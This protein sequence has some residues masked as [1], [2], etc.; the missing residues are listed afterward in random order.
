MSDSR[1]DGKPKSPI[2]ENHLT[3]P[4]QWIPVD[5]LAAADSPR[6]A[7]EIEEHARSL[8][9]SGAA[10]PPI[11]VHR[12]TM[13]VVDG[14]HRLRA[15]ELRGDRLIEARFVEGSVEDAFVLA[16]KLNAEHGMPLSR[17]DRTAAAVRIMR[18][19][20]AWSDRRIA[21]VTGLSPGAVGSLRANAQD[22]PQLTLRIGRDGRKRP[23]DAT[24]GR[25]AASRVI[26]E[27]PDASLREIASRA[28]IAV[29]TARDVRR[30]IR[31][32]EDPVA[33]KFR[34][35]ALH[36]PALGAPAREELPADRPEAAEP[37]A[38]QPVWEG[39]LSSMR[40]DPSLRMSEIGRTLLQLLRAHLLTTEQR[41]DLIAGIP[42][43]RAADV[44]Q[45]A[46]VCASRWLEF[47]ID[48]EC[49]GTAAE[50][51]TEERNVR[52]LSSGA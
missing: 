6:L 39:V 21:A 29:A 7:G 43:H 16:V 5:S 38:P 47:A 36:S 15:A 11:V 3:Q 26:A 17:Q 28:G 27:F 35:T 51:G 23:V 22:T 33:P 30:R 19:H 49:R 13:R 48:I 45:M 20:P 32:G 8:A 24:A 37:A 18:S 14:M 50:G 41:Q 9:E 31:L 42:A 46:R 4:T 25:L 2:D 34:P 10:L 12:P 52:Q 1:P 44:A 40:R